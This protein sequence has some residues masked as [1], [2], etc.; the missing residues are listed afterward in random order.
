MR[1]KTRTENERERE[2]V[3]VS[4][5]RE[6]RAQRE[7]EREAV[8]RKDGGLTEMGGGGGVGALHAGALA[9]PNSVR[10]CA[11][12]EAALHGNLLVRLGVDPAVPHGDPRPAAGLDGRGARHLDQV[13]VGDLG[14]LLLEGREQG[15][16]GAQTRVP[17][18]RELLVESYARHRPAVP[19]RAIVVPAVVP[20]QA[21]QDRGA[22]LRLHEARAIRVRAPQG[23][24]HHPKS[25]RRLDRRRRR[26]RR[27]NGRNRRYRS[28][29][30]TT[31]GWALQQAKG[32]SVQPS[33]AFAIP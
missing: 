2:I 12:R 27:R 6:A 18:V 26:R 30:N 4:R 13:R 23:L 24:L 11:V 16:R 15:H 19:R 10:R 8:E 32:R 25:R 29:R 28:P 9:V 17:S 14:V 31:T 5:P 3:W 1:W 22:L 20:G 21:H 33:H 7:R